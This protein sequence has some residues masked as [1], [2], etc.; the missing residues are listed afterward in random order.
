M[1]RKNPRS[2]PAGMVAAKCVLDRTGD[3][4]NTLLRWK[5]NVKKDDGQI[6]IT[7]E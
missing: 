4:V 5:L 2:R 6:V 1:S 3:D 7:R